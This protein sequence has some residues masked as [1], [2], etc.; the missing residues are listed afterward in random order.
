MNLRH[1]PALL[2]VALLVTAGAAGGETSPGEA[3]PDPRAAE[4]LAR[5]DARLQAVRSL[6]G[7]FI[8]TFVSSGL[9]IPQ[10]EEGTFAIRRP[11]RMRWDY[12]KPERKL[13]V[14]DGTHTWLYMPEEKIV[15]RGDVRDWKEGGPFSLLAGGSLTSEFV[16]VSVG[17]EGALRSGDLV[18]ELRPAE[19]RDQYEVLL[20]QF[21]PSSLVIHAV[22]AIDAMGN[23]TSVILGDLE[24][25][26]DLAKAEFT[27]SPPEGV[28]VV[29][30]GRPVSPG[31]VSGS[32]R[33]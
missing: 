14:S 11:D 21:D 10:T 9:G 28:R 33:R 32:S 27:F 7:T 18:L 19:P 22:T 16:A 25:N 12:V 31:D 1:P 4:I 30:Q 26:P 29:E 3:G 24:V 5:L 17:V 20:L 8:Q 13:A 15:Y 2:A 6:K 23:R